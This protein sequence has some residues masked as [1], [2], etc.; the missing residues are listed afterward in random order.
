ME[1]RFRRRCRIGGDRR[2]AQKRFADRD[3]RI[4]TGDIEVG[5][6]RRLVRVHRAGG[7]F[8]VVIDGKEWNVDAVRIDGRTLSLLVDEAAAGEGSDQAPDDGLLANRAPVERRIRSLEVSVTP[9]A[10]SGWISVQVRGV[11]VPVALDGRRCG[12]GARARSTSAGA[13]RIVA[14]MPGR[15]VRVMI[16]TGEQV[17]A[18]QTIVVVEAM[19]MENELRAAEDGT[20][21]EVRVQ[22][23]QSVEAGALLAVI[24]S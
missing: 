19:K 14:P 15:I 16:R 18:R 12:S 4:V 13:E 2:P 23:G 5:G 10:A 24:G 9:E 3:R 11:P 21:T 8:R 20:V 17:R 1:R 7:R 22:E 6:R